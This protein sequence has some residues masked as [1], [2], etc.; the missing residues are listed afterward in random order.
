MKEI[1]IKEKD[2]TEIVK[3]QHKKNELVLT[4][5]IRPHK[6]HKLF[7]FNVSTGQITL[8]QFKYS[9]I[10]YT[11][12]MK[13]LI[14]ARKTVI[15]KPNCIYISALNKKNALKVLNRNEKSNTIVQRER[16]LVS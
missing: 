4:D 9:D 13:G 1:T 2:I 16:R 6:G 10:H 8:A 14:N 11:D 5:T 15:K 3:L 7:E 12:A